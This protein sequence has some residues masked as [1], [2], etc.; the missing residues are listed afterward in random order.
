MTGE[1]ICKFNKFG[2]CKFRNTCFKKHENQKC[3]KKNCKIW[4]CSLRHP[5]TCRFFREYKRCKFGEFCKFSHDQLTEKNYSEDIGGMM[6]KLECL[7]KD[8]GVKD[9]EIARLDTEIKD[10]ERGLNCKIMNLEKIVRIL[11]EEVAGLKKENEK[12]RFSLKGS[13]LSEEK[14]NL[15][16]TENDD[17]ERAKTDENIEKTS[18]VEN[19]F[20]CDKCGFI[21]K[22][23]A[24]LKTHNTTKHKVGL[25]KMYRKVGS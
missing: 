3:E 14:N 10:L 4:N 12:L 7:K 23:E 19:E 20:I 24:G 16:D 25:M 21:G 11:Q 5:K 8:I 18:V 1:E 13:F 2:F 22:T 6:E 17:T 15:N 9:I